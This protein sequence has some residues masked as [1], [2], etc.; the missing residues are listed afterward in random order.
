MKRIS[1]KRKKLMDV[2]GPWRDELKAAVGQCEYCLKPA[3]PEFLDAH[4]ISRGTTRAMSLMADFAILILHRHCHAYVEK[5]SRARQLALL[6]LA[7]PSSYDLAKFHQL[8][9]RKWPDQAEID[10]QIEYLLSIRS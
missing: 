7:R 6:Y 9:R 4:E 5:W 2:A 8:V 3:A 1:P 10:V